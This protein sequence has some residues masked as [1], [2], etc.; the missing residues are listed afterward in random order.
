MFETWTN[1]IFITKK[2]LINGHLIEVDFNYFVKFIS[3]KISHYLRK[4]W[5]CWNFKKQY[6]NNLNLNFSKLKLK[7]VCFFTKKIFEIF[8]K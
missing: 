1:L 2:C 4:K 5:E 7:V 8:V 3:I 6:T